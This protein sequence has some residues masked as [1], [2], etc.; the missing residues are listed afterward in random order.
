MKTNTLSMPVV[1][2]NYMQAMS[3]RIFAF[4][5]WISVP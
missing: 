2:V 4:V 3:Q 5:K 1:Q